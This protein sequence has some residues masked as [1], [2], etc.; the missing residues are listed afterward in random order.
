MNT[1]GLVGIGITTL[2]GPQTT[3]LRAEAQVTES[4]GVFSLTVTTS[5]GDHQWTS[6]PAAMKAGD[7]EAA[8]AETAH[9]MG[10]VVQAVLASAS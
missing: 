5:F 4:G 7:W 6:S 2:A 10:C 1:T 9:V 8:R 3:D